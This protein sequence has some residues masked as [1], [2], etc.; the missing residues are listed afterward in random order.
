MSSA[1]LARWIQDWQKA[2][3]LAVGAEAKWTLFEEAAT[4][5]A[6][7]VKQN[8]GQ[9]VEI[10]DALNEIAAAHAFDVDTA[11]TVIADAFARVADEPDIPDEPP[12]H[13]ANGQ[14]RAKPK[15]PP[16]LTVAQFVGGFMPL[17]YLIHG[18]LQRRFVYA[19]T[20]Q[21]SHGKTSIAL[22]IAQLVASSDRNA[23]LGR[24]RVNKGRAIYFV[25]ENPDDVRMRVIGAN[26][27]RDDDWTTDNLW[28]VPG[29]FHI[30][31]MLEVL[32]ADTSKNGEP[33]LVIVDTSA[34]YFLGQDENANPQMAAHAAMLRKLTELPGGPCVLVLCHPIKH[35]TEPSQLLPRGGGAFLAEMDGNLTAFKRDDG[36]V[37]LNYTKI[38]GPGFEPFT[39]RLEAFQ[40]DALTDTDGNRLWTVR[41]VA[42]TQSDEDQA[43]TKM[44]ADDDAV[45]IERLKVPDDQRLS[46]AHIAEACDWTTGDGA[47]AK[48]RVQRALQR[49]ERARLMRND[50]GQYVLTEKGKDAARKAALRAASQRA[51]DDQFSMGGI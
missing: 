14:H 46:M 1:D 39:F 9:R 23:V 21:T 51:K 43:D 24:H 12:P 5:L 28:F 17:H 16:I 26:S 11:Q 31:D 41:A 34:A 48:V 44:A 38:R 8:G 50:R 6:R 45:L 20:G 7:R 35:A 25:G 13:K 3:A 2:L 33:V 42:V 37:E 49:L 30:G 4:D 27:R 10:A 18:M 15:L 22:L 40:A 29:R 19:L 32:K 36:L 47:P